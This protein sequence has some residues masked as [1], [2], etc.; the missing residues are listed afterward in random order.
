RETIIVELDNDKVHVPE[1]VKLIELPQSLEKKLKNHLTD[2]AH[3]NFVERY[4]HSTL[5]NLD[6]AFAV[7]DIM[8]EEQKIKFNQFA[9]RVAF[10]KFFACGMGADYMKHLIYPD[11]PSS[12]QGIG[13]LIRMD[14]FL[15]LRKKSHRKFWQT[16]SQTQAFEKFIEE[17]SFGTSLPDSR[18]YQLQWFYHANNANCSLHTSRSTNIVTNKKRP[19]K[20]SVTGEAFQR[21]CLEQQSMKTS[22]HQV[23]SVNTQDIPEDYTF[24]PTRAFPG[25]DPNLFSEPRRDEEKEKEDRKKMIVQVELTDQEFPADGLRQRNGRGLSVSA[26]LKTTEEKVK[27]ELLQIYGCWFATRVAALDYATEIDLTPK[28]AEQTCNSVLG[29]L[30]RM[31]DPT[32]KN[33]DVPLKPDELIFKSCLILCGKL[34]RA[35]EAKKIFGDLKRQ[36]LRPDKFTYGAYTNAMASSGTSNL[37]QSGVSSGSG[38]NSL[39]PRSGNSSF[40]GGHSKQGSRSRSA[41]IPAKS[42]GRIITSANSFDAIKESEETGTESSPPKNLEKVALLHTNTLHK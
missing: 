36:G 18:K 31:S 24:N 22:K 35:N 34:K 42:S 27:F 25:F 19:R 4:T 16:F 6:S 41:I 30:Y 3:V 7:Q 33:Y 17:V 40:S 26:K 15:K 13:D 20:T 28:I 38:R 21:W 23:P 37:L 8:K 9:C 12:I 14:D 10:W 39:D 29:V 32:S 1:T 11:D 2:E 5:Q